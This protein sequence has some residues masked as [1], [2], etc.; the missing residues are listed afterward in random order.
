MKE[1]NAEAGFY[2]NTGRFANTAVEY[3][4]QNQIDLY[5]SERFPILV[6]A[7]FPVKEEISTAK[8]MCL[9]CGVVL[10]LPV[11]ETPMS[12][13]CDNG[14]TVI[15]DITVARLL[16][17][18]FAPLTLSGPPTLPDVICNRCKSK[19]RVVNGRQGKFWGCSQYP[20]CKFT[21]RYEGDL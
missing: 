15:N 21:K 13:V 14:H 19:M 8:T 17:A 9:E 18:P 12:G 4:A 3:A 10:T 5:D 7:A 1:E 6:N 16:S 20:K 2:I 11:G